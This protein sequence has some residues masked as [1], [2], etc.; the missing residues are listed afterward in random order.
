MCSLYSL[1]QP[2]A[3]SASSKRI[4]ENKLES[5]ETGFENYIVIVA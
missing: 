3:A 4:S 5:I 1:K 2:Y